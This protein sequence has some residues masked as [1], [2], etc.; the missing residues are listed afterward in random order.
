M[1]EQKYVN[2]MPINTIIRVIQ[3]SED[4]KSLLRAENSPPEYKVLV[5]KIEQI[6]VSNAIGLVTKQ[7][8][9]KELATALS[10]AFQQNNPTVILAI[11]SQLESTFK[12]LDGLKHEHTSRKTITASNYLTTFTSSIGLYIQQ[13]LDV[14]DTF[15]VA[16]TSPAPTIKRTLSRVPTVNESPVAPQP[17]QQAPVSNAKVSVAQPKGPAPKPSNLPPAL[18]PKAPAKQPSFAPVLDSG[19]ASSSRPTIQ[20]DGGTLANDIGTFLVS[21]GNIPTLGEYR[22]VIVN[23]LVG[24]LPQ[25]IQ[26]QHENSFEE[27]FADVVSSLIQGADMLPVPMALN[28][29]EVLSAQKIQAAFN[30]ALQK[31]LI[32]KGQYSGIQIN[33]VVQFPV[34]SPTASTAASASSTL[35]PAEEY[36]HINL[37]DSDFG[38][39]TPDASDDEYSVDSD[40]DLG[41]DVDEGTQQEEKSFE[42]AVLPAQKS[43]S[44]LA[45][46]TRPTLQDRRDQPTQVRLNME[47]D[48]A[49]KGKIRV[50]SDGRQHFNAVNSPSKAPSAPVTRENPVL[51]KAKEIAANTQG[52]KLLT[53]RELVDAAYADLGFDR[54]GLTPENSPR[55]NAHDSGDELY[56]GTPGD[57]ASLEA[58]IAKEGN[59]AKIKAFWEKLAN[60]DQQAPVVG[61]GAKWKR[62]VFAPEDTSIPKRI[63]DAI[64]KQLNIGNS[65]T[66]VGK[67]AR[68]TAVDVKDA[69]SQ[70]KVVPSDVAASANTAV[71]AYFLKPTVQSAIAKLFKLDP[72]LR[73][74]ADADNRFAERMADIISG[75]VQELIVFFEANS[76]A[77]ED[78]S[79]APSKPKERLKAPSQEKLQVS[80]APKAEES[81]QQPAEAVIVNLQ[82]LT[83]ALF[84]QLTHTPSPTPSSVRRVIRS[85]ARDAFG[86]ALPDADTDQEVNNAVNTSIPNGTEQLDPTELLK[87]LQKNLEDAANLLA[88]KL[89]RDNLEFTFIALP[90]IT[91]P[92]TSTTTRT[93]LQQPVQESIAKVMPQLNA[94]HIATEILKHTFPSKDGEKYNP[95]EAAQILKDIADALRRMAGKVRGANQVDGTVEYG[96]LYPD[97][98]R[99]AQQGGSLE[100]LDLTQQHPNGNVIHLFKAEFAKVQAA[101]SVPPAQPGQVKKGRAST[102]HEG[103]DA[104]GTA[105]Y[106]LLDTSE[107]KRAKRLN[108]P[109]EEALT[110]GTPQSGQGT[111]L[112]PA[113]VATTST[114]KRTGGAES[115]QVKKGRAST[116]HE[117]SDA[118]GT[119]NYALLDTSESKRAKR[120]NPPSEEALTQGTPQSGRATNLHPAQVATTSNAQHPSSSVV[121]SSSH[122]PKNGTLQPQD[123]ALLGYGG[124]AS[125]E[126]D[127]G[128]SQQAQQGLAPQ[129]NMGHQVGQVQQSQGGASPAFAPLFTSKTAITFTSFHRTN[130]GSAMFSKKENGDTEVKLSKSHTRSESDTSTQKHSEK[131]HNKKDRPRQGNGKGGK[132]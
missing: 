82:P 98:E 119:A 64:V 92:T 118:S 73:A 71:D 125:S 63:K 41:S 111:N 57:V 69:L 56:F 55:T 18:P 115:G 24:V 15:D 29:N 11:V 124:Q 14:L 6:D 62:K 12:N 108:P 104:S 102:T 32:L 109:S 100:G 40:S 7:T 21:A 72:E 60:P 70:S 39:D 87:Q 86:E 105:N 116:T 76:K 117:G 88:D 28:L 123:P 53:I 13:A 106:A 54:S 27:L 37:D 65:Q 103:S 23:A 33:G 19:N 30:S 83:N 121:I 10:Y 127:L 112:H 122:E 110:Q 84:A 36:T 130:R 44:P 79:K 78:E 101:Q 85:L 66:N 77:P 114:A 16:V 9:A 43:S 46:P 4:L 52:A 80:V 48:K 51:A 132:E 120:L 59:V 5:T 107:S 81:P 113:Q 17:L 8:L 20:V 2:E 89:G 50:G 35:P 96:M 68:A 26:Q 47:V 34:Q 128:G 67:F 91:R 49:A 45:S 42:A 129:P 95:D 75:R 126:V 1:S 99:H 74:T 93:N 3:A 94:E 25:D 22:Q 90:T 38:D 97:S 31:D 61:T 131:D 58:F